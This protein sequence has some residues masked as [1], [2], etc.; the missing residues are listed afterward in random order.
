MHEFRKAVR[1]LV[2][3]LCVALFAVGVIWNLVYGTME[4]EQQDAA[5]A[6]ASAAEDNGER[7]RQYTAERMRTAEMA[8]ASDAP[9]V[10][11]MEAE[12]VDA[13]AEDPVGLEH[14]MENRL[15]ALRMERDSSWKQ[16]EAGLNGLEFAEKQQCLKQYQQLQYEEQRLELL[17]KAKGI[18]YCLAV[19]GQQQANII[20]DGAELAEHYEKIYDLVQR[21]TDYAPEQIILVPLAECEADGDA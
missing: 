4:A 2:I 19:L 3:A 9:D 7:E 13:V 12:A 20:V 1:M 16:L 11:N 15:A 5:A 21:N 18:V 14:S 10:A 8:L 17:L 6:L